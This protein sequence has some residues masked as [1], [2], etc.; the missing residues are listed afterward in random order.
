MV[1]FSN[2]HPKWMTIS[3]PKWTGIL[4]AGER[5]SKEDAMEILIRT[6]TLD[7]SCND[8]EWERDLYEVLDIAGFNDWP[9]I[10]AKQKELEVLD[11]YFLNNYQIASPSISGPHG[12]CD[13]RGN[14]FAN[15]YN[16]GKY[17][18]PESVYNDWVTIAKAFPFLR[19]ECQLLNH[20][21]GW[22]ENTENPGPVVEYYIAE[23]EVEIREPHGVMIPDVPKDLEKNMFNLMYNP[24]HERGCDIEMFQQALKIVQ[25]RRSA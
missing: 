14:I 20:E 23:G 5:V 21:V 1:E 13:W 15:T 7:F 19:L 11:L 3:L 9:A 16:I 18:T 12:W 22:Y 17:P 2:R 6:D 24:N 10:R 4:V 8:R 25:E